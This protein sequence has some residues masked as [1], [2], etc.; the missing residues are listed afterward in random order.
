[1]QNKILNIF[2]ILFSFL[3]LNGCTQAIVGGAT[4]GG[5]ILVQER[6]AKQAG[7]D[8]LIKT[9]I[10]ESMFS[11]NYDNL[12]SK[13]RVL[14]YEGKVLLVGTVKEEKLINE[15][16]TI[17]WDKKNVLEVA[18]YIVI[19]KN[20]L[21]DYI[22]DTR[23]SIELKAKLLTDS[24]ISE[25]NFTNTTENRNLF[26]MGIARDQNEL[27]KVLKHAAEI[28]GVKKVINLIVLKDDPKRVKRN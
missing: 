15:A 9:Q 16:E 12:F 26:I 2:F 8:I 3:V 27:E 13:I 28:A 4:S 10:E 23:I 17:A 1:M 6:S 11:R 5:I 24:E 14:V 21:V 22:K 19:G 25:V 7:I 20:D 18:N